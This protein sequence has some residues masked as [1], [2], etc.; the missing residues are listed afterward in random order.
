M[1]SVHLRITDPAKRRH[2]SEL[3]DVL[4]TAVIFSAQS[5]A[6]GGEEGTDWLTGAVDMNR[7]QEKLVTAVLSLLKNGVPAERVKAIVLGDEPA[8]KPAPAPA[9]AEA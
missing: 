7:R 4:N 2:Y 1:S 9:P 6:D 8:P 5:Q 3:V